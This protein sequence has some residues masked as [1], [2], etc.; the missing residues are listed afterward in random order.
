[1]TP[2]PITYDQL[3]AAYRDLY[4]LIRAV[5]GALAETGV[6][7]RQAGAD[8]MAHWMAPRQLELDL[9]AE[10]RFRRVVPPAA[11]DPTADPTR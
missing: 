11:D 7:P 10:D 4:S 1:V 6:L 5:L 8:A 3:R 2:E 9:E